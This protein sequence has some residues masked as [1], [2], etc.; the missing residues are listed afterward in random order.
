[1]SRICSDAPIVKLFIVVNLVFLFL[2][3]F[4]LLFFL[5]KKKKKSELSTVCQLCRVCRPG[6][7]YF[8]KL[9]CVDSA[10]LPD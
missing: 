1:M 6:N 8:M 10:L 3:F 5:K 7:G 4:F 9:I 2:Q